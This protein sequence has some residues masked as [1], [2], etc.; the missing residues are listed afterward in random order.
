MTTDAGTDVP[1]NQK[2]PLSDAERSQFERDGYLIIRKLVPDEVVEEMRAQ[3]IGSLHPPV[4]PIEYEA[5]VQYPGAPENLEVEGGLTPRRLRFAY[6]RGDLFRRWAHSTIATSVISQL[7]P[8]ER[9]MLSQ[10]HHNCIMTKSPRFSSQTGWHRDTRYWNFARPELVNSWLALGDETVENGCM[11][12][13]PGSH[14]QDLDDAC[15]DDEAFFIDDDRNEALIGGA[16]IA[17]LSAGDVLFFHAHA[18]HAAGWN[19]TD[20]VKLAVVFTYHD[21]SNHPLPDTRS[22]CLPE[23]VVSA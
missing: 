22:A 16:T 23:I 7:L 20:E 2:R 6:A 17:E 15:F 18:L 1:L 9:L 3:V 11:R 12:L 14:R 10:C 8:G 5:E 4:G 21:E 19:R 13:I